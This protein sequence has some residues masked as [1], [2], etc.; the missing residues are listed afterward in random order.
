M[1]NR[2]GPAF[3]RNLSSFAMGLHRIASHSL[4]RRLNAQG[5]ETIR[6]H[7]SSDL[8]LCA[9]NTFRP[10]NAC[11]LCLR[12]EHHALHIKQRETIRRPLLLLAIVRLRRFQCCM[13]IVICT[14]ANPN[15][16]ACLL[17][18]NRMPVVMP[19]KA[20]AWLLNGCS[21]SRTSSSCCG[22]C[23][24]VRGPDD[25]R[26]GASLIRYHLQTCYSLFSLSNI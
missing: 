20:E 10:P 21:G 5:Q 16:I 12:P 17:A 2:K 11:R 8:P 13:R 9:K 23:W 25:L 22:L 15:M 18:S 19:F 7:R 4:S 3:G 24:G 1:L 26:V 14:V 6:L